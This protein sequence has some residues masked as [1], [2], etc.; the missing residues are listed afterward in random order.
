MRYLIILLFLLPIR[1]HTQTT[2]A[3]IGAKWTYTQQ[4]V[5]NGDSALFVVESVADTLIQGR[6][7]ARLTHQ[8]ALGCMYVYEHV[9]TSG[10]TVMFH[11]PVDDAFRILYING[12]EIGTTWATV[13]SREYSDAGT[14]V[15]FRD[16]LWFT[17]LQTDTALIDGYAL[18]RM[19]VDAQGTWGES[20]ANA[21]SPGII[22]ERLGHLGYLYP[23]IDGA[24]DMEWNGP[25]RCYEDP[26]I[27]WQGPQF[28]QCDLSVG[29]AETTSSVASIFPTLLTV[30]EPLQIIPATSNAT[31]YMIYDAVGK[32]LQAGT[33]NGSRPIRFERPGMYHV[34]LWVEAGQRQHQRVV[35]Q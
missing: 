28:P 20:F 32:L 18:R 17:V 22:V 4:Y 11:D 29:V 1:G 6:V 35:V 27:T 34:V 14:P 19:T 3:P 31:S 2:F 33:T 15:I 30:G 24:C 13:V 5:W 25:L 12:A 8:G 7:C 10:D 9:T 26:D 16:T 23:W 21:P